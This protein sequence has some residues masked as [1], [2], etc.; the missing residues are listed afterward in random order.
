MMRCP[1]GGCAFASPSVQ[2]LRIHYTVKHAE[3][4]EGH[5]RCFICQKT[6]PLEEFSKNASRGSRREAFCRECN[7]ARCVEYQRRRR[8]IEASERTVPKGSPYS[9][10]DI[11]LVKDRSLSARQVAEKIGRTTTDVNNKRGYLRRKGEY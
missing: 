3:A 1:E 10:S 8:L 11:A 9:V 4:V 5:P 7:T 2:G 6:K